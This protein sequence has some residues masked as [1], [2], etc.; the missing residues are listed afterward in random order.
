MKFM[1]VSD[2]HQAQ[3]TIDVTDLECRIPEGYLWLARSDERK[4]YFVNI[5][6]AN[7]IPIVGR[8]YSQP[9][10][11]A[12]GRTIAEAIEAAL[13]QIPEKELN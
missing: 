11:H 9:S 13:N 1:P 3:M 12:Y 5:M 4:G 10:Y 8:G 7:E 6:P 2:S